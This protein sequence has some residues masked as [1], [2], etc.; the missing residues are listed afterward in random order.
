[1]LRKGRAADG[2]EVYQ[3]LRE[4]VLPIDVY[5]Q[6]GS[7]VFLVFER[8]EVLPDGKHGLPEIVAVLDTE[9]VNERL[10][11]ARASAFP[12]C[13]RSSGLCRCPRR[14]RLSMTQGQTMSHSSNNEGSDSPFSPHD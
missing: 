11:H 2:C 3:R 9:M 1:M 7:K 8:V 12:L 13:E 10:R 14:R 4:S 5:Y 6:K